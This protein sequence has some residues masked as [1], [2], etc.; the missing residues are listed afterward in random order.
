[1]DSKTVIKLLNEYQAKG[2]STQIILKTILNPNPKIA[3]KLN[4]AGDY[5]KASQIYYSLF[6]NESALDKKMRY[7]ICLV[8]TLIN[9]SNIEKAENFLKKLEKLSD[10]KE[11]YMGA[12]WEKKGWIADCRNKWD[13]E[14]MYFKKA[15]EIYTKNHKAL[16]LEG[17]KNDRLL[18]VEHFIARAMYF[19]GI[20]SDLKEC[21]RLFNHNLE[22]Y[23]KLKSQA[24][25]AFN[26]SWL[27]R[28]LIAEKNLK[29]AKIAV[30]KSVEY[31][32]KVSKKQGNQIKTY[33][34]KIKAELAI[35]QGK[36]EEAVRNSL[37]AIRYSLP[38]GTYYNGVIE[39]LKPIVESL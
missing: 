1:M 11:E 18:T 26:Y 24:A 12:I 9:A 14:I 31:F 6:K 20:K 2:A 35:A 7:G 10:K 22:S 5:N 8:Q 34:Y 36:D 23:K 25:I 32:D 29:K 28:C 27:A 30:D 4:T 38:P 33:S 15:A 17:Y 13:D 21:I 16:D 37:E 19:R 3:K 39:A